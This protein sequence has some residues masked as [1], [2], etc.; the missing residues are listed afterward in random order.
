MSSLLRSAS[1]IVLM[2]SFAG[3][4]V[5]GG[6]DSVAGDDQSSDVSPALFG[7]QCS[8]LVCGSNSP[9]LSTASPCDGFFTDLPMTIGAT[10]TEGFTMLG[11]VVAGEMWDLNVT[12]GV[13]SAV[14]PGNPPIVGAALNNK[15]FKVKG[16]DGTVY[17]IRIASQANTNLMPLGTGTT[18]AYELVYAWGNPDNPE[19]FICDHVDHVT[20]E[21]DSLWQPKQTV[22]LFE[23]EL[24]NQYKKTIKGYSNAYFNVGCAGNVLS[25]M[26]LTHHSTVTSGGAYTTTAAERQT[27]LKMYTADYCRDG[28]SF[29]VYG[30]KLGW[31]DDHDWFSN[32]Y[33]PAPLQLE[34]R[35][36]KDG[37]LCLESP[38]LKGTTDP[39]ANFLWPAASG[40]VD[41]AIT[42]HCPATRP[43]TCT[44]LGQ[45]TDVTKT[46]SG[47]L[48]SAY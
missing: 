12:H 36:N 16:P 33:L 26:D 1:L 35:W 22:V 10:N 4:M 44:S 27:M 13:L 23:G 21:Y 30:E 3:C 47:H 29:T 48:V 45:S 18:R 2:G 11:M 7:T 24:Y 28:T 19:Y 40:G 37:P 17:R 31:E 38:R 20:G 8:P 39:L 43:P 46:Y 32:Y 15:I 42:A 25:K 14:K 6:D 34:A 9:C 41:G 5:E